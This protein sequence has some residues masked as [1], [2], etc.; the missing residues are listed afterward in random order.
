MRAGILALSLTMFAAACTSGEPVDRSVEAPASPSPGGAIQGLGLLVVKRVREAG[1]IPTEGSVSS[2][3]VRP[4]RGPVL[5]GL[6]TDV[7]GGER[8]VRLVP[9]GPFTI[10]HAERPCDGSCGALDPPINRCA[11]QHRMPADTRIVVTIAVS[12][13][14]CELRSSTAASIQRPVRDPRVFAQPGVAYEFEIFSHCGIG[15]P[16]EFDGRFWVPEQARYRRSFNAPRGFDF[17]TDRGTI[18]LV[19]SDTARYVS[20]GGTTVL[21]E[22]FSRVVKPFVCY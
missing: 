11:A 4:A 6:L 15:H 18:T 20:S 1:P 19:D 22:P 17:N 21:F 13:E 16:I 2:V 9:A 14:G 8:L 12:Y 7:E 5:R 3:T 10:T